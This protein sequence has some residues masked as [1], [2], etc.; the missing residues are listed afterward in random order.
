MNKNILISLA[1]IGAVAAMAIGGTVAYFSDT[2]TSTGNTFTAGTIDINLDPSGGQAVKTVSGD[3]DLKPS[4]VGYTKAIITNVGTNPA[5]IW[6]HIGNVKNIENGVGDA[7]RKFYKEYPD[8]RNWKM[9]NWIHY[10]MIVS[11]ILITEG[12]VAYYDKFIDFTEEEIESCHFGWNQLAIARVDH[13]DRTEFI[14][15]MPRELGVAPDNFDLVFDKNNDGTPDFL[16]HWYYLMSKDPQGD[17]HWTMKYHDGDWTSNL[18]LASWIEA[19]PDMVPTE[20]FHIFIDNERIG[21]NYR[22]ALQAMLADGGYQ[23]GHLGGVVTI[24]FPQIK[25]TNIFSDSSDF[26]QVKA[27]DEDNLVISEDDKYTLTEGPAGCGIESYWMYLGKLAPGESMMVKQSYHLDKS[28]D[29]WAQS[30]IV[31]FDVDFMAL[32]EGAEGP[33]PVLPDCNN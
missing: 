33:N 26:Y 29:N 24:W 20:Q 25:L 17:S 18:E 30:D 22:F 31:K 16:I 10:D 9:S 3:L 28:V 4:E 32:Q 19:K 14:I 1:V 8:S 21:D 12:Y 11:D 7:E 15:E 2:E 5:E 27:G 6:K 23:Q 13:G